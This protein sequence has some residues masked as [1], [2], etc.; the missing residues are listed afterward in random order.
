MPTYNIWSEG[1]IAT[2][3][4]GTAHFHGQFEGNSFAEAIKN[5]IKSDKS[6]QQYVDLNTMTYWGC[7]LFDNES[8]ARKTF[9]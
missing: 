3:Q 8:D 5:W 9:G 4:H 7:R 1:F 2:G 6:A